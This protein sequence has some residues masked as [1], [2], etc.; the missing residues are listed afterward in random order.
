[1]RKYLYVPLNAM[2]GL[3]RS[4]RLAFIYIPL[5]KTKP[6]PKTEK[7]ETP[8]SINMCLMIVQKNLERNKYRAANSPSYVDWVIPK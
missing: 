2:I 3:S 4:V 6:K 1:M 7:W 5:S 8:Y